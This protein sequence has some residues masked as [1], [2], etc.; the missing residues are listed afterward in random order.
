MLALLHL[1]LVAA[2]ALRLRARVKLLR[3]FAG[4]PGALF[5]LGVALFLVTWFDFALY[6]ACGWGSL[7]STLS[8][9]GLVGALAWLWRDPPADATAPAGS[10]SLT[11]PR[12]PALWSVPPAFWFL[13]A[14]VVSRF[15]FGVLVDAEGT[16]WCNFNFVD[17][18][19]HLSIAQALLAAPHWPPVDLDM[20]PF[21]L[22]YHF[23]ADFAV[24]QLARFG[25][26]PL[27][28][29][30]VLNLLSAAALVGALWS[31]CAHWLRLS[32][33]WT[34][35]AALLFLFLN[36]A[37]L[38][39]V[40]WLALQPP[41]FD[42]SR[43]FDGLFHYPYFNFE[44][45]LN[46]LIEP[47]RGLLFSLPVLLLILHATVASGRADD[48]CA[49]PFLLPA[50]ALVCLLPFAHIVG[51]AV[52]A[53]T[54]A[55]LLWLHRAAFLPAW[56]RWL[57]F[58]GVGLAQLYYLL[59]FGPPTHPGFSGWDVAQH[60]SLGEFSAFP[61]LLRRAVFWF[62]ADGDF[63]VWG[64][65][66]AAIAFVARRSPATAPL[67]AFLHT[68]RWYFAATLA[69][70]VLVNFYRYA[71][72][73]G[74]S[75]KFLLFL[76][77]ALALLITVGA[78]TVF[79]ARPDHPTAPPFPPP[80]RGRLAFLSPALWW[81]F[82]LLCVTP[83]AYEFYQ[84]V[85]ASPHAKIILFHKNTRAAAGWL[86]EHT[87]PDAVVLTGAFADAHWLT[88]LAGRPTLAGIYSD[89]NPYLQPDRGERIRRI[90]EDADFS[91]LAALGI[92]YV[93]LSGHERQRYRLSPRW[94][95]LMAHSPALVFHNGDGPQDHF[96][97]YLFDAS[98][99]A[100]RQD[101]RPSHAH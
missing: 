4:L 64:A 21:P 2:L 34:L 17:T 30:R 1:A 86:R 46:N 16:V 20:A 32:A 3:D 94:L 55:P 49:R 88:A 38:N 24:A 47:Q 72:A 95:D 74:D 42:L 29:L 23:L 59:A 40:H 33:R 50:F 63:L 99:L 61:A 98:R 96:S 62:F 48:S 39:L 7:Q 31:A 14:L 87:A 92:R 22:K 11:P 10:T 60:L 67:R 18:A 58:F 52:L 56:P 45:S 26:T 79:T 57:P 65:L 44:F 84:W 68:W 9:V 6:L 41:F 51:F 101:H 78:A 73:W 15:A 77:L 85:I 19:F 53:L 71:L 8:F 66:F 97:V 91:D 83:P 35:L 82:F 90:Y 5:S 25:L 89:W 81:F 27:T 69:C 54:L 80:A 28:A 76:H 70:F 43:P 13:F 12:D 37:L 36:P 93:C 100:P 75:N